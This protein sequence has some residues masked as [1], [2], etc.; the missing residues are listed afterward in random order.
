MRGATAEHE[1]ESVTLHSPLFFQ[2]Q[3]R[4][5]SGI[6]DALATQ[7]MA[8]QTDAEDGV[9]KLVGQPVREGAEKILDIRKQSL[10]EGCTRVSHAY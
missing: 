9:K 10:I 5:G 8:V 2:L 7:Y 6:T 4:Q 3:H 1:R